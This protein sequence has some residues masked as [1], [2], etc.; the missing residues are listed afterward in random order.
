MEL[1]LT[2][3][4]LIELATGCQELLAVENLE[5]LFSWR[6]SSVLQLIAPKVKAYETTRNKLNERYLTLNIEGA[7]G[8]I[9]GKRPTNDET[10]EYT[11][12][13]QVLLDAGVTVKVPSLRMSDILQMREDE[14]LPIK[15][16]TI[17]SVRRIVDM[18]LDMEGATEAQSVNGADPAA[19]EEETE[20]EEPSKPNRV[21]RAQRAKDAKARAS[22]EA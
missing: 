8:E 12:K 13:L 20:E 15:S 21:G 2:N 6:V 18:D 1:K 14:G 17:H 3:L 11:R 7:G 16:S 4:E 22:A 9:V 5:T 19:G 10:T